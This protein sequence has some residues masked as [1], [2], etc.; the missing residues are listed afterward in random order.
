MRFSV[1]YYAGN[2]MYYIALGDRVHDRD[3]ALYLDIKYE[4]YL[5]ILL[6]NE[7][8]YKNGCYFLSRKQTNDV[9]KILEPYLIMARLTK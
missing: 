6:T 3:I 2:S 8:V 9:I 1:E 7:A 4:E 5:V